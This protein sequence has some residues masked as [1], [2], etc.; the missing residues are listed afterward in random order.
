MPLPHKQHILWV[1]EGKQ[2]DHPL[3]HTWCGM[4]RRCSEPNIDHHRNYYWKG[5][6][7]YEP[8]TVTGAVGAKYC[9]A[10]GFV[11][12]LDYVETNL[13]ARPEGWSLDRW[14]PQP[15]LQHYLPGCIR[16]APPV[17]QAL[18]RR[19]YSTSAAGPSSQFK[20]VT[21]S[22]SGRYEGQFKL[23]DI[24]EFVG[25]FDTEEEAYN[26]VLNRRRE[27]GIPEF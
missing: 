2:K 26:A 19:K 17:V 6:R 9:W 20:W 1:R 27:L 25:T 14:R 24:R 18:N 23:G 5:V 3:Y 7:V 16:W 11:A 21:K 13:G 8:W 12:W 10:P 4:R 22:A 15:E